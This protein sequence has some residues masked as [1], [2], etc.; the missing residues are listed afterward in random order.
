MPLKEAEHPRSAAKLCV[1]IVSPESIRQTNHVAVING[2]LLGVPLRSAGRQR[3][4]GIS[5]GARA[6]GA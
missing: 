6:N 1:L 5:A 3:I 2:I 4:A